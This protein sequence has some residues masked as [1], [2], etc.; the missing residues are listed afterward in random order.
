MGSEERVV[1]SAGATAECTGAGE[2][3]PVQ[4]QGQGTTA[5]KT[6]LLGVTGCIA[7][8]KACLI[9][10]GL[11]KASVR[12][13]VVMTP[14]ATEFVGA[15]TFRALTNEEVAVSL[16]DEPGAPIHHISLAQECDLMLI[17]PATANVIAKLAHGT[18]DDLLTTT[19]LATRAPL[20]VAPAMND[21]MWENPITQ[22]NIA[23]LRR[24]GV[25]FVMPA[26][27][28]L[29]CGS[30]GKG[31]L[32]D[33]DAIVA[34]VL[35]ELERTQ[36]LAGKRILV[37]AGPTREA[38]DPVRYLS[39]ASS[40]ITGYCIAAEAAARGAQVTLVSGPVSLEAPHGVDVVR[41][42]SAL[43][44][45]DACAALRGVIDAAFFVAAV[46]DWRPAQVS[47]SKLPSGKELGDGRRS[48][49]E[50]VPNPDIA[51]MM[52]QSKNPG[53]VNVVFAAQTEDPLPAARRKLESKNADLCIANNVASGL[54]FGTRDNRVW[55]VE[56][57]RTQE[58]PVMSKEDI[59][60]HLLDWLAERL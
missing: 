24:H 19:A 3:V 2:N 18:A 4:A 34:H 28:Y 46:S 12:V 5:Q 52:G 41:V 30:V 38:I 11:Q 1:A 31:R 26:S 37:T 54:G 51:A 6:V 27:G 39:N 60:C 20:L 33:P 23:A 42:E 15:T 57:D 29:A 43:Q 35:R 58:L 14:H 56:R 50:L 49:I 7:A 13:K 55:F 44:M 10:R 32:E 40:G 36:S 9:V 45:H 25:G 47:A 8:Y 21:G 48:S 17:A 53:Q 16:F 22:E 59:A